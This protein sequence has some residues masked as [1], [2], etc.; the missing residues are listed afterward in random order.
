MNTIENNLKEGETLFADGRIDEA[1]EFFLSVIEKEKNNK[2][3]YNNLGVVAIQKEDVKGAIEYFTRSLEI[4]PFYKDAI[5]N[6]TDL[7]STLNQHHI[8]IPLL[9]K[10]VEKNPEDKEITQLLEDIRSNSK[11]KLRI[12]IL[13][14]SGLESFLGDIVN[15]LKTE[16]EVRTC[17]TNNEQEIKSAVEWADIVWLEWAN[18]LTGHVTQNLPS[19]SQK[20][21]ICRIHRYEVLTGYIQYIDWTKIDK[22]VFVAD[23]I[24]DIAY[25]TYPSIANETKCHV[26]N[27]GVDMQKFSFKQ[28]E[29][30][31]NLAVVTYIHGR[32]NPAMWIEIMSRLTNLNPQYKLKV[33][34]VT[35]E[36]EYK[37]YFENIIS[38]LGLEKNIE[39]FGKIDDIPRWLE[40]EDINYLLTTSVCESFGYTIA[41]AM[42]MG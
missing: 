12:A 39:F 15:F 22:A 16:Y 26:I 24:R 37:Y 36:K 31:F 41:E 9:E 10:L 40:K 42:A 35:Q 4:D 21:V 17:Y 7:L 27:N 6:Y 23:H 28:R 32:K 33:A 38:Q 34:G 3:A 1:E 11:P 29:S 8:A 19:I 14:F 13:C 30:G 5:V 20:K 25:E 2:E 18:Q